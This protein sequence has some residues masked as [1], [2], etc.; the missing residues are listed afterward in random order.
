MYL[1]IFSSSYSIAVLKSSINSS[2]SIDSQR[3]SAIGYTYSIGPHFSSCLSYRL[4]PSITAL[5][6]NLWF[7]LSNSR[8]VHRI[9]DRYHRF[10]SALDNSCQITL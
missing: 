9:A 7:A 2:T 8:L 1:N 3:S 4:D 6:R 10:V 5:H